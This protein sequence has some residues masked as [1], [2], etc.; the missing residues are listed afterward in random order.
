MKKLFLFLLLTKSIFAQDLFGTKIYINPGHGGF[1]SNDRN[2][3]ET[4]FWESTSNLDKG[5][6]LRTILQKINASVYMSRVANT[7]A[8]DLPLSQIVSDANSKNVDFFHAIHS[9][10]FNGQS[11]YTLMLFQGKD[12]APTYAGALTMGSYL[13][14]EIYK[15]NRTTAKYNRGDIDFY[16]PASGG[17]PYLGVF[18]NLNVPGTLSEG[19]FHDYI[20]ES[21]RLMN[22]SYK[23]HEAWAI[24][25]GFLKYFTQPGFQTGTV[26]GLVRDQN[27][28]VSYFALTAKNDHQ[29][30]LNNIK[31]TLEP[32]GK[33]Y[34]GDGNNNGFFLFDSLAPGSYKVYFETP[35]YYKDSSTVTVTANVSSFAD[36]FLL[37]DTTVVAQI[38][39]YSPSSATDSVKT[40]AP[41]SIRFDLPMD[42]SSTNAAFQITP[43]AQ[44]VF[45]WGDGNKVFTFKPSLPYFNST[46]YTIVLKKSAKT[47][48]GIQLSNDLTFKFITKNRNR[49]FIEKTYPAANSVINLALP[50]FRLQFEAPVLNASLSGQIN[51]Y[52]NERVRLTAINVKIF[53]ENGKGLIYFETKDALAN[54]EYALS[55]G[56]KIADVDSIPMVDSV[57][58]PF[59]V[60]SQL[61]SEVNLIDDFE[62]Q[63]GWKNP[64]ASPHTV[65]V[66]TLTSL[67]SI[68][69]EKKLFGSKSGKLIYLFKNA[70]NGN[71]VVPNEAKIVLNG[72]MFGTWV[73]GDLSNNYFSYW[74]EDENNAEFSIQVDSLDWAGW[75]FVR[76]ETT[77]YNGRL[78]NKLVGISVEQRKTGNNTGTLFFDNLRFYLWSDIA[79]DNHQTPE[80][81]SLDQ[82]YPNPFNP[83]TVI[84]YQLPENSFVTLKIF[85]VLGNEVAILV[86]ESQQAGK[87]NYELGIR[88]YELSSGVYFYQ[89]RAGD[90][91]QT[92]KMIV[93]K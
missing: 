44:G 29:L 41:V 9:N 16:A 58:I 60:F 49:Y 74:F 40:I 22:A 59:T 64:S 85:D 4:G 86:N 6:A 56:G 3:P 43:S 12:N 82:N 7:S 46:E 81:Y 80:R 62:T 10:G 50:Q 35:G 51:L 38:V 66:D 91:I 19:S 84:S 15:A 63:I 73:F 31:V 71:C 67:F 1:D 24:A 2:I 27:K 23:K 33:V 30:P 52:N 8:D 11:N 68:S 17:L 32:G 47:I 77:N 36:K 75:K 25:R 90:F 88:N 89:L 18:K 26:A 37:Y 28:S 76:S 78:K 42:T 48:W 69:T 61:P 45:S 13:T 92:K 87:H 34:N 14:D 65:G 53:A 39:S 57:E 93:L 79:D 72:A 5:L 20:P 70:E 21:W 54:G 55:L 83:E